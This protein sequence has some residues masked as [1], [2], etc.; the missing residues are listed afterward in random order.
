MRGTMSSRIARRV[1][2]EIRIMQLRM[3]GHQVGQGVRIGRSRISGRRIRLGNKASVGDNVVI[4]GDEINI[5]S[6]VRIEN[7]VEIRARTISIGNETLIESEVTI[8]GLQTPKS[9]LKIGMNCVVLHRSYLNTTYPLT[10]EDDVG[11]G[12]Y[13]MIFTHGLWQSAFEGYPVT[14][15]PVTIRRG[16]WLPWHVFVMP[17]VEIGEGATLGAGSVVLK[18]VPPRSLAVG[19]PAKVVKGPPD[20]PPVLTKEDCERLLFRLFEDFAEYME[21]RGTRAKVERIGNGMLLET[22]QGSIVYG[23]GPSSHPS[24]VEVLFDG[25]AVMEFWVNLLTRD[26]R[27]DMNRQLHVEV[28][29]FLRRAGVRLRPRGG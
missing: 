23:P 1:R 3:A 16:V 5:G 7:E 4:E 21:S 15:A 22:P 9:S 28:R 8:G 29:Q 17:G 2:S 27:L 11:V 24:A 14:F 13:C 19:V 26:W 18:S 12:G 20:Y 6:H 10:I 25:T